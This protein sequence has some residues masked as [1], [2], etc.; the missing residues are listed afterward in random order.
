M[1]ATLSEPTVPLLAQRS[2]FTEQLR[3]TVLALKLSFTWFGIRKTLSTEQKAQ[4]AE[5][6]GASG[7][8]LSAGKKLID[9]SEPA[10]RAV[11]GI[12]NRAVSFLKHSSLPYPEAGIRL[13][14]RRDLD[15]IVETLCLEQDALDKAVQK[16]N[17]RYGDLQRAARER[18]GDLFNSS[19]YPVSLHGEFGM[20]WEF[21][22][23]EPP[24]YL[25]QL[26]PELYE[27]E[28]NRVRG[29]FEE[30]VRMAETAFTEELSRLIDQLAE[31]LSG[32]ENGKPKVFRDTAVENLSEFFQRFQ[33][34]SIG[35]S[36]QLDALVERSQQI[37]N[38]VQ[39]QGLRDNDALRQRIATQLSTVQSSLDGLLV[40][41]PRR[42]IQR[43]SH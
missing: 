2:D 39:P 1:S 35:S 30:A 16:L 10:F 14:R 8:F 11:T 40:D 31:R 13:I 43:R 15:H 28:S 38:G 5:S 25:Q 4:A 20:S 3:N 17:E 19:D 23:V 41:R 9:T 37:L 6:F 36:E 22:S 33:S 21:P 12:R 32:A 27:Q 26:N 24:D 29:R 7:A 18:L 42:N 34:L